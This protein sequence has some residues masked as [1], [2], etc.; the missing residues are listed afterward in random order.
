M[1]TEKAQH[2]IEF[3]KKKVKPNG[4]HR[5][6]CGVRCDTKCLLISCIPFFYL[7]AYIDLNRITCVSLPQS[8]IYEQVCNK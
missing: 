1:R 3:Y 8:E 7:H 5:I 6:V 4:V 2:V